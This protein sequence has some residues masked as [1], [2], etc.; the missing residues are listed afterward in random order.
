M[1]QFEGYLWKRAPRSKD[2]D[3]STFRRFITPSINSL[4]KRRYFTLSPEN[5]ILT[6][7]PDE[8][9]T[10]V[11]GKKFFFFFFLLFCY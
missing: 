1:K 4:Y 3:K 11:L 8:K 9:K 5:F 10:E 7:Y 2:K 6:Y